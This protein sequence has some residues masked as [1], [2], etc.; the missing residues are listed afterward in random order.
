MQI[1]IAL[2][3]S[4]F[5]RI[6]FEYDSVIEYSVH[7]KILIGNQDKGCRYFYAPKCISGTAGM[8]SSPEEVV[9]SDFNSLPP[10]HSPLQ[11][12]VSGLSVKSKLF[13]WIIWK[14]Y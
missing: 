12:L 10:L 5:N 7:S 11:L 14:F 9:F 13:L 8:C 3:L 1:S 6:I 4:S 2:I